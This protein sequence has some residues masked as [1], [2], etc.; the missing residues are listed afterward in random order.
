LTEFPGE[1]D[2]AASGAPKAACCTPVINENGI[3]FTKDGVTGDTTAVN[4]LGTDVNKLIEDV[5]AAINKIDPDN[6]IAAEVPGVSTSTQEDVT[7]LITSLEHVFPPGDGSEPATTILSDTPFNTIIDA[8]FDAYHAHVLIG[9]VVDSYKEDPHFPSEGLPGVGPPPIQGVLDN[10]ITPRRIY[11][12]KFNK[13]PVSAGT[14]A[15]L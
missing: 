7:G 1:I 13:V 14:M 8:T 12:K 15:T 5:T 11:Y 6:K 3:P 10:V 9:L 2:E 4:N